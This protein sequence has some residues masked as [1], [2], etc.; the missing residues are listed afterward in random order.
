ML[1]MAAYDKYFEGGMV[2]YDYPSEQV[3]DALSRIPQVPA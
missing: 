3:A 2:D 1:D